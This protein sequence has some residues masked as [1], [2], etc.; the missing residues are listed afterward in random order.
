MQSDSAWKIKGAH[1][2]FFGF[3]LVLL[4]PVHGFFI[5]PFAV[6][7]D[8]GRYFCIMFGS[9]GNVTPFNWSLGAASIIDVIGALKKV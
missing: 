3:G 8:G 6:A 7:S 5:Q 2:T 9:L 4:M 1:F